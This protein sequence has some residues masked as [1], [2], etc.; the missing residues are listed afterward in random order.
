MWLGQAFLM[1]VVPWSGD[2]EIQDLI[3]SGAVG[4]DLLRPTDLYNFWFTRAL[5]LRTAPLI[6]RAIPLL[7]V[8][9][10]LFPIVG[11]WE[12]SL[13]FPPSFACSAGK[14]RYFFSAFVV[15]LCLSNGRHS[16]SDSCA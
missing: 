4:Y 14:R 11:L 3:R 1:A 5:A 15:L 6:L 9:T 2:G 13:S 10:F 12:R 7:C 8:T 16:I